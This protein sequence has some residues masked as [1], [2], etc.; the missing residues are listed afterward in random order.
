MKRLKKI[1]IM[2]MII[3]CS[4]CTTTR[5]KY[6]TEMFQDLIPSPKIRIGTIE[7]VDYK[8]MTGDVKQVEDFMENIISTNKHYA[9]SAQDYKINISI[10]EKNYTKDIEQIYTVTIVMTVNKFSTGDIV[11]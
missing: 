10:K 9:K 4:S 5:T 2:I 3:I 6:S 1:I 7:I 8:N 11:Y